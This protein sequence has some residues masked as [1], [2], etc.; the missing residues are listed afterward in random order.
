[1]GFDLRWHHRTFNVAHSKD[2]W[3]LRVDDEP[4]AMTIAERVVHGGLAALGHPCCGEGPL[5]KT[6]R[7]ELFWYEVLNLPN[8]LYRWN[9]HVGRLPLT[10]EQA[11]LLEPE[12]VRERRE[13]AAELAA[14]D[15]EDEAP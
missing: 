13:W 3:V 5:G 1:M 2:G 8:K 10:E 12:H 4:W 9:R 14:E 15:T 6:E 7:L 11:E